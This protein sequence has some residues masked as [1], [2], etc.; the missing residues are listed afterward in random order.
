VNRQALGQ[1]FARV[2]TTAV[3]RAPRLWWL[4][5]PLMRRQ[6]DSIAES[7]DTMRAPGHLAPFEHALDAVT[8]EPARVLDL[9][10]GT[11]Q[12]AFAVAR[13]FPQADVVGVDLAPAMLAEAERKTP[14]ELRDRVRFERGD[15]ANLQFPDASFDLVSHANM[16]PFLDE[17]TRVL[18]PGGQVIFAFSMGAGTPIYVPADRLQDELARRGFTDFAAIAAGDGTALLARKARRP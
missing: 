17:I 11:G 8:P 14:A 4:F 13:R 2:T 5:R 6:F 16:I 15:A 12:A 1:K 18:R 3:L 10:T 9:G 7:W